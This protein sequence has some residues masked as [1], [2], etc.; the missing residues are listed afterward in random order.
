MSQKPMTM[1]PFLKNTLI[2]VHIFNFFG[3]YGIW[4]RFLG[5]NFVKILGETIYQSTRL[6]EL[7]TKMSII[8]NAR[9][10]LAKLWPNEISK[11]KG[12]SFGTEL[13]KFLKIFQTNYSTFNASLVTNLQSDSHKIQ[14]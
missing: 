1:L 13:E 5:K 7:V 11:V 6:S 9:A 10:L 8:L 2:I 3:T 12:P 4:V 14:K